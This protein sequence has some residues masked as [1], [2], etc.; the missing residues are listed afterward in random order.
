M[1]ST[2]FQPL[3]PLLFEDRF[4]YR[5]SAGL[6]G[7]DT[8]PDHWTI[9]SGNWTT[10]NESRLLV[11]EAGELVYSGTSLKSLSQFSS[12]NANFILQLRVWGKEDAKFEI[13][14]RRT[15][16]NNYISL[17]VDFENNEISL[18]KANSGTITTLETIGFTLRFDTTQYSKH[19]FQLWMFDDTITAC[20]NFNDIITI[21]EADHK[22][23]DGFSLAVPEINE[24]SPISF[25]IFVAKDIDDFNDPQL[26]QDPSDLHVL[27]RKLMKVEIETPTVKD[28]NTFKRAHTLYKK[29]KD[30]GGRNNTIWTFL[31]YPV[32]KPPSDDFLK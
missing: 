4:R 14:G 3:S 24:D 19:D 32:R 25:S 31:G 5:G 27:F 18:R 21:T 12:T 6:P 20:A 26:E 30:R 11:L 15:D 10:R 9:A 17:F 16:A 1:A 13:R 2:E 22:T 7:S 28:W 29:Y 23:S 8:L